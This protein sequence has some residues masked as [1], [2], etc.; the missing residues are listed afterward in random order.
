[1]PTIPDFADISDIRQRSVPDFSDNEFGGKSLVERD[2]IFIC[3]RGTG[4]QQFRGLVM[5][6]GR[7]RYKFEFSFVGNVRRISQKFGTCREKKKRSRLS[8]YL[9]G[10]LRFRVFISRQN[11][12][13]LRKSKVPDRQRFSR[14]MKTWLKGLFEMH[15]RG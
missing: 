14:Q 11:Q 3:D 1:M 15:K 2:A 10:Y 8:R 12:G 9:L 4:A 7:R 13:R 6:D 5:S